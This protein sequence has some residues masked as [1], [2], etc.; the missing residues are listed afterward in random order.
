M[1][2]NRLYIVRPDGAQFLIAKSFGEGWIYFPLLHAFRSFLRNTTEEEEPA[3]WGNI[4]SEPTRFRIIAENE[5][6]PGD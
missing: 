6:V 3:A 4:S 5:E 2:N 1:A